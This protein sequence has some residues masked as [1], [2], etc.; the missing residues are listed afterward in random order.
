MIWTSPQRVG[1]AAIGR[2]NHA[3]LYAQSNQWFEDRGLIGKRF[4]HYTG[5][6]RRW[7]ST[8]DEVELAAQAIDDV[9]QKT[10]Y[11]RDRIAALVFI[12]NSF[13]AVEYADLML[14]NALA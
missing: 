13:I 4:T 11:P 14:D 5:I 12:S 2:C 9:L 1:M 6:R 10:A 7:V 3:S 8:V